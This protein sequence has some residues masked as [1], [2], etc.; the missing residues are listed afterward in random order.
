VIF[1]EFNF[2][3]VSMKFVTCLL[4]FALSFASEKTVVSINGT[5]YSDSYFFTNYSS[6]EW[7]AADSSRKNDMLAEFIKQKTGTLEARELNLQ[8]FPKTRIKLRNQKYNFLVNEAYEEFV[9][10]EAISDSLMNFTREY[11]SKE[12]SVNHILIGYQGCN[13]RKPADRSIE[14]AKQL[15][16]KV[17]DE[18]NNGS[19]FADLA[20][21]YSEDP[22]VT[23]NSGKLGWLA[24]GKTIQK[25]QDAA[26][27]TPVGAVSAPVLTE[28]GYH[29]ILVD[30]ERPS[31]YSELDSTA[32]EKEVYNAAVGAIYSK[33]KGLAE[34]Y[35]K[36][37]LVAE[38]VEFN[39]PS[40][41]ITLGAIKDKINKNKIVGSSKLN[42][43]RTLSDIPNAGVI[44]T[45]SGRG[46]GIKWFAERLSRVPSSRH[47]KI[48]TIDDIGSAFERIILQEIAVN[49]AISHDLTNRETFLDHF[50]EFQ[51]SVLFDSYVKYLVNNI[52]EPNPEAISEYYENNKEQKFHEAEKV[53]IREIKMKN[54]A[55]L[56][57][58]YEKLLN[59]A[60][61][62]SL[63]SRFS[64]TNPKS[65]GKIDPFTEGRYGPMGEAAFKLEPGQL[66][67]KIEN[68]D[69]TWS[70]IIVQEKI[71]AQFTPLD[72]VKN[73]IVSI[74]KRELQ[75]KTKEDSFV[76]LYE[77]YKV[78]INPEFFE[79]EN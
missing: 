44:C 60:D 16:L 14:E 29:I 22:S 41:Q 27:N 6:D 8:N 58:I 46:Y 2:T 20:N 33:L 70:V 40:L 72:K 36:N 62:V 9:A 77:K 1:F 3:G 65:G 5:D 61:F 48:E 45:F 76:M 49:K 7:N 15:A 78:H 19:A 4:L 64:Y 24:V 30:D 32:Y 79:Y 67:N 23:K 73:R 68:L 47:P 25:F 51:S 37:T 28:Y 10:R 13:L 66:S 42:L 75:N 35:D 56:D 31:Q 38:N 55:A 74:L 12:I 63:A 54:E 39:E 53:S 43:V 17:I 50:N 52:S 34:E 71:P 18:Y 21:R 11:L 69:G 59:G 26:F 57:S